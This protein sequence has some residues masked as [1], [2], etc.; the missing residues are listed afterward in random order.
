MEKNY[1]R[2]KARELEDMVG[3]PNSSVCHILTENL[4]NERSTMEQK[5]RFEDV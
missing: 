1:R 2:L 4:K 3:I 5:Q